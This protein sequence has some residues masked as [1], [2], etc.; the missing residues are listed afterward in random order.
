[1]FISAPF[2]ASRS[3]TASVLSRSRRGVAGALRVGKVRTLNKCKASDGYE[4]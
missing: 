3:A 4:Q 2:Q 1:M